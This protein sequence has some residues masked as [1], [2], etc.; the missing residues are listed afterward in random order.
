M[1]D[2]WLMDQGHDDNYRMQLPPQLIDGRSSSDAPTELNSSTLNSAKYAFTAKLHKTNPII[3]PNNS[4]E[5]VN[6]TYCAPII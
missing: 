2:Q 1:P 5:T 6:Y 3:K 4:T